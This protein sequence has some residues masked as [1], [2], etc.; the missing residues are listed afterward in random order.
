MRLSSVPFVLALVVSTTAHGQVVA[1]RLGAAPFEVA[2]DRGAIAHD[3]RE[4]A[5]VGAVDDVTHG[6]LHVMSLVGPVLSYHREESGF[7]E[8]EWFEEEDWESVDLR[9]GAPVALEAVVG[10]VIAEVHPHR[11]MVEEI[12]SASRFAEARTLSA[13]DAVLA[14]YEIRRVGFAIVAYDETTDLATF[15]IFA[16]APRMHAQ[17]TPVSL[18]VVARPATWLQPY[19]SAARDGNGH[20]LERGE[21][22]AR[23]TDPG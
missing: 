20:L 15:R 16:R 11:Y 9:S 17:S 22:D 18:D 12:G 6:R 5:T 14:E 4:L 19:A 23:S 8:D 10:E 3:G 1:R 7:A 2:L 13:I 21:L